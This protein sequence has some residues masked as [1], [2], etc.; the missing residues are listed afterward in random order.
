[1][2]FEAPDDL[3]IPL[4]TE[5]LVQPADLAL[6]PDCAICY[7]SDLN[8]I[9]PTLI[10]AIEFRRWVSPSL[11][12]VY[13]LSIGVD[14]AIFE[15]L[16]QFLASFGIRI[17]PLD[18][19]KI[20]GYDPARYSK[21]HVPPS[22]LGRFFAT[23]VIPAGYKRFLYIDGDTWIADDPTP[24]V[25]YQPPSGMI[26]AAEDP[27]YYFHTTIGKTGANSRAYFKELGIDGRKGYFNAGLILSDI[28]TWNTVACE[29][30]NFFL[31]NTSKCRYHDQSALNAVAQD[32]RLRLSPVWNFVT[33]YCF[34]GVETRMNPRIYHF[35][36]GGKPWLGYFAPWQKIRQPYEAS[37]AALL[38]LG[39]PNSKF[40]ETTITE[41]ERSAQLYQRK[42]RTTFLPRYLWFRH[43][44]K[45]TQKTAIKI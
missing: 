23:G 38:P 5:G 1:M 12:D 25:L 26:A 43:E 21:T 20:A 14:V 18:P 4:L 9:L 19:K 44:L 28:P 30:F 31:K 10:S 35:T 13:I 40:K 37:Q 32:R 33:N 27:S 17:L 2:K 3:A 8:F 41:M 22:T 15:R 7:V 36:G 45:L 24:L 34:W 11:A 29:A 42:L 6:R 39:L 16:A